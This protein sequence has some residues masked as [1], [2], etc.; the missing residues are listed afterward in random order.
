MD[1]LLCKGV[2]VLTGNRLVLDRCISL[3]SSDVTCPSSLSV[4]TTHLGLELCDPPHRLMVA[5]VSGFFGLFAEVLLPGLAVLCHDWPILQAV[6][7]LPLVLLL[8]CW[9]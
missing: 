5:M 8:S 4:P 9:W 2:C 7:T 6:V 3:A 1:G